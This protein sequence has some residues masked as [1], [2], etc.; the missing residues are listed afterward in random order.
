M[1]DV[2]GQRDLCEKN[3]HIHTHFSDVNLMSAKAPRYRVVFRDFVFG[4]GSGS[5]T[6]ERVTPAVILRCLK[7]FFVPR[8]VLRYEIRS[9]RVSH[10]APK[11]QNRLFEYFSPVMV[12]RHSYEWL[13]PSC[14]NGG[15][16]G[17]DTTGL[18]QL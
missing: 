13:K 4:D 7:L 17:R 12:L 8:K 6:R 9:G 10:A 3:T 18:R 15:M 14:G 2:G 5:L 16:I 11:G 1:Q